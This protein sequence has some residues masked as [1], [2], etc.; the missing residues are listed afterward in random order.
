MA[1]A[2]MRVVMVAATLLGVHVWTRVGV[3]MLDHA[4]AMAV[5]AEGC[6]RGR[7]LLGHNAEASPRLS[8]G[9]ARWSRASPASSRRTCTTARHLRAKTPPERTLWVSP[10]V[11]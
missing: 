9:A 4:V 3:G 2:R 6:V 7:G 10:G 5:A 11:R 8:L 1:M